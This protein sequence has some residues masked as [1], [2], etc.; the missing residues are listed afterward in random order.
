MFNAQKE[1]RCEAVFRRIGSAKAKGF[2][3][4]NAERQIT[5]LEM[6]NSPMNALGGTVGGY[7]NVT[8][9]E[10]AHFPP[11]QRSERKK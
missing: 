8:G 1:L 3:A 9:T 4:A 11:Y 5:S 2:K 7:G 6:G 10:S